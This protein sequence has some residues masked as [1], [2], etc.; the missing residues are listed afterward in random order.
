MRK[1]LTLYRLLSLNKDD[2]ET[3]LKNLEL[4][5]FDHMVERKSFIVVAFGDFKV[6]SRKSKLKVEILNQP[7]F[8]AIHFAVLS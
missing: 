2:F 5:N 7:V 4:L 1:L 8:W 6:E 3:F